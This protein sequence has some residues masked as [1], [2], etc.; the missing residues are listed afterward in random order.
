MTILREEVAASEC[1][2]PAEALGIKCSWCGSMIRCEGNQ[3]AVAMCKSCYDLMM[4]E[5][6]RAQRELATASHASD[7]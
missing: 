5:F 4:T 7:R 2:E 6:L 3:P 1:A